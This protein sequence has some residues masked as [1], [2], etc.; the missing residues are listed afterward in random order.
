MAG[1]S[2]RSWL[3]SVAD[4]HVAAPPQAAEVQAAASAPA[5]FIAIAG[6]QRIITTGEID[7][8]HKR[9]A[10]GGSWQEIRVTIDSLN[11]DNGH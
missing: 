9:F 5:V 4:G 3:V 6:Y 2:I 1:R 10:F 8:A 7:P 11:Q